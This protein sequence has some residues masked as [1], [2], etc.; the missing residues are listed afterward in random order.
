MAP[1]CLALLFI[2]ILFIIIVAGRPD[3]F[4][5][6]RTS[7]IPVPAEKVFAQVNELR[8]WEPWSPWAKLDPNAKSNYEG[9]ASGQ[10]AI[11]RWSGNNKVGQGSMTII[12]SRP[13]EIIRIKLEFLRPFKATN[14]AELV[15]QSRG[16][17]TIVSWSMIG[18]NNFAAKIFSLFVN[19]DDMIGKCFDKGLANLKSV[20][21]S[22]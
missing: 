11:M 7:T 13:N 3:E 21:A 10:G 9:P 5:V 4:C 6:T 12:E 16:N 8:A 20:V 19:C 18:T 2:L 17:E 22:K 1:I 14:M 15:F